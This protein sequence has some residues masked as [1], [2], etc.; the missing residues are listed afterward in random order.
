MG[1]VQC[2][3]VHCGGWDDGQHQAHQ[4]QEGGE[5]DLGG[6]GAEEVVEGE[7]D[8]EHEERNNY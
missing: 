8:G 4:H 7:N 1:G 6:D 5:Y 3:V 2:A